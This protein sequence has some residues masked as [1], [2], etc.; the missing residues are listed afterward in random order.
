MC[1]GSSS[2]PPNGSQSTSAE[3]VNERP[4]AQSTSAEP[5]RSGSEEE[6]FTAAFS[7]LRTSDVDLVSHTHGRERRDQRNISRREL[8]EAVK[9]GH[10][11]RANPSRHGEMRWRFTYKGIV[12]VTDETERHEITS[13]RIDTEDVND[14][15]G[16]DD[17]DLATGAYE[18]V[19]VVD[20]SGSMRKADIPGYAT[21]TAAV[22][23][24]LARD[25]VESQLRG[26]HDLGDAAVTLIEMTDGAEVSDL[27]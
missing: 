3:P 4:G 26:G 18:K 2:E 14:G 6:A 13:W 20:H 19:I 25:L 22:Y 7:E 24:C 8:Q 17:A 27:Q 9:H 21:R 1:V 12:Y 23:D 16:L 15:A 11:E 10:R 5:E